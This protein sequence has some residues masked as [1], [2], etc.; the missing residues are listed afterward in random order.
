MK[1]GGNKGPCVS[2]QTAACGSD[3]HWKPKKSTEERDQ[4][5]SLPKVCR[6]SKVTSKDFRQRRKSYE[7]RNRTKG[8]R[9]ADTRAHTEKGVRKKGLHPFHPYQKRGKK[10]K[11]KPSTPAGPL[12]RKE[13]G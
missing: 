5:L 8:G 3:L 6:S 11:K 2:V 9:T 10:K 1:E 13:G 4:K 12:D 7:A